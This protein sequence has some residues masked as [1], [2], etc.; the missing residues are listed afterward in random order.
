MYLFLIMQGFLHQLILKKNQLYT[1]L[2]FKKYDF[3]KILASVQL[4][5]KSLEEACSGK[6]L[7]VTNISSCNSSE[8]LAKLLRML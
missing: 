8:Q 3:L 6:F 7:R 1:D 5:I 2:R 4:A